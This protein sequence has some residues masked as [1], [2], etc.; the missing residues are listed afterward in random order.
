MITLLKKQL[1]D[2]TVVLER[3][4]AVDVVN[5]ANYLKNRVSE[6]CG[7]ELNVTYTPTAPAILVKIGKGELTEA[8]VYFDGE[9]LVLEGGHYI[10]VA[11]LVRK[12][13]DCLSS[14]SSLEADFALGVTVTDIP[15]VSERYP[16]MKL[17]WNDE[18]DFD[19]DLYDRTKWLQRVQMAASDMLN[20]TSERNVKTE[21]GRLILRSWR[22]DASVVGKPYSTNMS[23]TTRDSCNYCYGY[24]EMKAKVPFGK[25]RW[26][27]FWM[28]QREDMHAPGV[29]WMSEIDIFEVFGADDRLV[30][31]IHK[32]CWSD[33]QYHVQLGY[34]RKW[35][36]IFKDFAS[37]SEEFHTYGFYWDEKRMVFSVDGEDY[38]EFDITHET[39][40]FGRNEG[41]EGFHT[42]SYIILNNFVFTPEASWIPEGALVDE[43]AEFPFTYEVEYMRLWQGENGI[44]RAPRLEALEAEVSEQ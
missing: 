3:G 9:S 28:V 26:P 2:Y 16:E 21:N 34:D 24:L 10:P 5:A 30:P 17:V 11:K 36:Y 6:L 37:L 32:W 33:G 23:M 39:G 13:A 42:P 38:C 7:I 15:L 8:R 22:E 43:E 25:G 35:P 40:D 44:F 14:D 20:G 4:A 27:S 1:A 41:M 19:G 12:L 31:N 29:K 18:F